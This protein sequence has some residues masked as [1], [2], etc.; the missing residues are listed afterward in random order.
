MPEPLVVFVG[1]WKVKDQW[2]NTDVRVV[3]ADGIAC[4]FRRQNQPELLPSEIKLICSHLSRTAKA[5]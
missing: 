3:T 2:R 1:E 5:S 4:Y